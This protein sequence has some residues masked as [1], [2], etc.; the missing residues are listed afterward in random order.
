[1]LGNA[2]FLFPLDVFGFQN[3]NDVSEFPNPD[4][5]FTWMKIFDI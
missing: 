2:T 4:T 3:S 5:F 1:M